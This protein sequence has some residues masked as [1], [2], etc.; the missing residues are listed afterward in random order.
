MG[1]R[2]YLENIVLLF[3]LEISLKYQSRDIINCCCMRYVLSEDLG[4]VNPMHEFICMWNAIS[5]DVDD[6][7]D[8]RLC[9]WWYWYGMMLMLMMILRWNDVD[10]DIE[11]RWCWCWWCHHGGCMLCMYMRGAVTYWISLEKEVDWFKNFK[12]PW[13]GKGIA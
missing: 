6:N 12:R 13:R 3:S 9:W 5:C 7:I 2:V 4:S 10:D 8:M 11:M 1:I